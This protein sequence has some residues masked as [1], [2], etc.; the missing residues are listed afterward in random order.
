LLATL[1]CACALP[2][3]A[4]ETA[5]NALDN[6]SITTEI[7]AQMFDNKNTHATRIS[8]TTCKGSCS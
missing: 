5:G 6:S 1:A 7:K 4:K 2:V 3:H 8:V